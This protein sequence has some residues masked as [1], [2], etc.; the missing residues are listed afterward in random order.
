MRAPN[1]RPLLLQGG[2][3]PQP[4]P[5]EGA[6]ARAELA[7]RLRQLPDGFVT[8]RDLQHAW[9]KPDGF[10]LETYRG[11]DRIVRRMTCARCGTGRLDYHKIENA[12]LV[13]TRSVYTYPEGFL[14]PKSP[15][16]TKP[17]SVVRAES[18]RRALGIDVTKP[19]KEK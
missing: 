6:A 11:R 18:L 3:G 2:V 8:C 15:P 1:L 5:Y 16:G 19:T 9:D 14:L 10:I 17:L 12:G 13:K 7:Q 4:S